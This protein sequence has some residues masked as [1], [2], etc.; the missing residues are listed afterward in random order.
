MENYVAS[1]INKY[2]HIYTY[3]KDRTEIDFMFEDNNILYAIEVK[4]GNNIHAKSLSSL[5]KKIMMHLR[6][7]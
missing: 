3:R 2:F 5:K 7:S 4:S 1:F 6:L